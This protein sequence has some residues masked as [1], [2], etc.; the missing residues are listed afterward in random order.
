[1]KM[2]AFAVVALLAL[3]SCG[4]TT[5]LDDAR[6]GRGLDGSTEI[7]VHDFFAKRMTSRASAHPGRRWLIVTED[8]DWVYLA[9]DRDDIN[10]QA[11]V[12]VLYRCGRERLEKVFP[13]F[14]RLDGVAALGLINAEIEKR[15]EALRPY[16]A[17]KQ[18]MN[19]RPSLETGRVV[20]DVEWKRSIDGALR[21][22]ELFRITVSGANP[23]KVTVKEKPIEVEDE[24]S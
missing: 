18:R 8:E 15:L 7:T 13:G 10:G 20:L 24:K 6:A 11:A 17:L 21:K 19:W 5:K 16:S 14:R 23:D 12:G 9:R 2:R 1:M 22:T 4:P 3:N